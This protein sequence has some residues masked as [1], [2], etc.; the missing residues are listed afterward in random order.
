MLKIW[1]QVKVTCANSTGCVWSGWA[2]WGA[3]S[4]SCNSGTQ[5]SIFTTTLIVILNLARFAGGRNC[6]GRWAALKEE[7][8]R[9]DAKQKNVQETAGGA[10]GAPGTLVRQHVARADKGERKEQMLPS[11]TNY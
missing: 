4:S 3:C 8:K 7:K 1:L 6:R 5:V 2:E 10:P 11:L 9:E